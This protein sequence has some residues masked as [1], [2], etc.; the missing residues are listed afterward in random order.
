MLE[1][2]YYDEERVC[3]EAVARD[4]ERLFKLWPLVPDVNHIL[5][6]NVLRLAQ[7]G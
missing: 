7:L 4:N 2:E 1:I 6:A 5:K 3:F